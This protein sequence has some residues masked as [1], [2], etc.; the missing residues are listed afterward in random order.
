MRGSR[1]LPAVTAATAL[2]AAACGGAADG[3]DGRPTVATSVYPL[4]EAATRVGGE[5][6][7][8]VNLTP[9]GTEPHDVEL[10][11]DDVDGML[12]AHLL[13]YLGG[14]FQPAVEE[15][16][17]RRDGPAIDLLDP[18]AS[19]GDVDPHIWLDPL[20]MIEI[21]EEVVPALAAADPAGEAEFAEN[22]ATYTSDLRA[23]HE[24]FERTLARCDRRTLVVSHAA[25]GHLTARYGLQQE[26]ITG[27]S[28]E[29]EP[30]PERLAQLIDLV[31]REGVTTIFTE[32][33]VSPD[34]ADTL[35]RETGARTETL[36]PIEG[37]TRAEED[38]GETYVSLMERNL[39]AIGKALGCGA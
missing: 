9:A 17:A 1:W 14:G 19:G 12:D 24:R 11:P 13:L 16:A 34:V 25:F 36:N 29:S 18:E 6:V 28:P 26:P 37:L 5:R 4:F 21:V 39:D 7:E 2:L 15:V 30:D 32:P 33:L 3:D 27:L 8:V 38:A 22:A 10:S 23:L 35:A 31:K 20:R